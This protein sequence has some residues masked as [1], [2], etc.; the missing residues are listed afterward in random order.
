M[1]NTLRESLLRNVSRLSLLLVSYAAHLRRNTKLWQWKTRG[2]IITDLAF[3]WWLKLENVGLQRENSGAL[4]G[5]V[6][7]CCLPLLR[8]LIK[9]N[10][11]MFFE[12]APLAK[13]AQGE[14]GVPANL[15]RTAWVQ[16]LPPPARQHEASFVLSTKQYACLYWD[17]NKANCLFFESNDRSFMIA[18]PAKCVQEHTDDLCTLLT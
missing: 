4:S 7:T 12:T 17:F 2:A 16:I 5:P 1:A 15:V 8:S 10:V 11:C 18:A 14:S 3:N 9:L 13:L 6:R